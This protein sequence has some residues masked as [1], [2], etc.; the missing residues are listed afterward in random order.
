LSV[1]V[2]S[3][4]DV[5]VGEARRFQ[6]DG[7]LVAVINVGD[8]GFRAI[9]AICSHEKYFLDEG[10]V[11]LELGTIECPKHGSTFSVETGQPRS[12]PAIR[13]VDTYAVTTRGDDIWIEVDEE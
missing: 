4:T 2:C 10:D 3:K 7:K 8:G 11:D 12:L 9:D 13:P 5:P 6:V 1:R